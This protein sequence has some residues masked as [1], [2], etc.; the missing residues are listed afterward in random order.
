MRAIHSKETGTSHGLKCSP[1]S[2]VG[3]GVNR[4]NY[5]DVPKPA[6]AFVSSQDGSNLVLAHQDNEVSVVNIIAMNAGRLPRDLLKLGKV[7]FGLA[8]DFDR[9]RLQEVTDERNGCGQREGACE[10]NRMSSGSQKF[11]HNPPG[12]EP[13]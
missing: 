9:R 4:V 6:E 1:A 2:Q 12:E 5:L 7:R 13:W 10:Y 8:Q 11:V 3:S